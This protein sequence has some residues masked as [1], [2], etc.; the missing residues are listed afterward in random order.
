MDPVSTKIG[1]VNPMSQ[2]H[3]DGA[4]GKAF[5]AVLQT[6]PVFCDQLVQL[7]RLKNPFDP[8]LHATLSTRT[9]TTR[10]FGLPHPLAVV[11]SPHA[12]PSRFWTKADPN[13][14]MP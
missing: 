3:F 14:T 2:L 11:T 6:P 5:A 12:S 13:V 8:A 7:G 10:P 9:V 4:P 1:T